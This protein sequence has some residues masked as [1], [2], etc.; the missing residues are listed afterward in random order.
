M[1][2]TYARL[3]NYIYSEEVTHFFLVPLL[4]HECS[5]KPKSPGGCV[6]HLWCTLWGAEDYPSLYD[7]QVP[8]PS[9]C[10]ALYNSQRI[11]SPAKFVQK[12]IIA[13]FSLFWAIVR[14]IPFWSTRSNHG[15]GRAGIHMSFIVEYCIRSKDQFVWMHILNMCWSIYL[16]GPVL[17]CSKFHASVYEGL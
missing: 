15:G 5:L 11:F 16:L 2:Y 9:P 14:L 1:Q 3:H 4:L 8:G 7:Y 17:K 13:L 10:A 12:L 6:P